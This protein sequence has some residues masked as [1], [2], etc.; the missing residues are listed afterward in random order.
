MAFPITVQLGY[1][2]E[3]EESSSQKL[4]LGTRG[5]TPDGRVFYY[6]QNS[7][8]AIASAGMIVDGSALVGDHDMDLAP[9]S[10]QAAGTTAVSIEVPTTNLTKNQYKDG[11]L[12]FNDGGGEGEVYR[13]REHPAHDAATDNTVVITLDE[14][15][16]LRTAITTSTEAQLVYNPYTAVKLLDGDGTQTTGALGVTTIPVS[17][18]YYTWIQTSGIASVGVGA[19]VAIVGDALTVSQQAGEDGLAERTD[20]SDE[21]DIA[22]IGVAIGVAS[23]ATDKQLAMLNIRS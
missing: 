3:K 23:V 15:D 21:A 14:I 22:N 10:N 18:S 17:A 8:V 12:V 2:Q 4:K 19:Q 1:G 13:I 16:G 7:G 11:Y 5:E 6:A 20:Y 9:T